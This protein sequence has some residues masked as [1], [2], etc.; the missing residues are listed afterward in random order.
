MHSF[1][2]L[3]RCLPWSPA[4]DTLQIQLPHEGWSSS[5]SHRAIHASVCPTPLASTW[6]SSRATFPGTIWVS[7][8]LSLLCL[9]LPGQ[10]PK[11]HSSG[12]YSPYMELIDGQDPE[13]C[14]A[15]GLGTTD[16]FNVLCLTNRSAGNCRLCWIL[17]FQR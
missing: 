5:A 4:A 12:G 7:G 16:A 10:M 6:L 8:L 2:C 17:C 11:P 1:P 3:T 9:S 14:P 13:F 15:G